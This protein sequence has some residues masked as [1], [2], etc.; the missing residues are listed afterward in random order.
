MTLTTSRLEAFSALLI[1]A[2]AV[3]CSDR[4]AAPAPPPAEATLDCSEVSIHCGSAPSVRVGPDG[5]LWAAFEYQR[6]VYL[7]RSQ[8]RGQSFSPPVRVTTEEEAIEVNGENRPKLGIDGSYVYFSWTRKLEGMFNADI[9][10]S[11]SVDGG[12]TFEPPRTI[13][14][15]GLVI[16]HR[17]DSL[18]IDEQGDLYLVWIDKRDLENARAEGQDYRGAAIYY[19]VSTDQGAT[20]AANRRVAD[21]ACECCRI[22]TTNLPQRGIAIAWRHVFEGQIRDHAFATLSDGNVSELQRAT[23]DGWQIE[24]C[25]HHGPAMVRAADALHLVWFTAADDRPAAYHGRFD[26]KTGRLGHQALITSSA[27]AHPSLLAADGRLVVIWKEQAADRTRIGM[28]N[29]IDGGLTWSSPQIIAE[30]AGISDHPFLLP[31]GGTPHLVWHTAAE[32][33][34]IRGIEHG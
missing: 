13:N 26:P 30:T 24:A 27:T 14:D 5:D 31:V 29:S 33:L 15:D 22:A 34:I 6:H 11:R 2:I 16:G 8:D 23:E 17:F 10:F 20:F 28:R 18:Q 7:S 1:A 32:G 9:R 3:G 21:H 12:L 25:P 4:L 19:S